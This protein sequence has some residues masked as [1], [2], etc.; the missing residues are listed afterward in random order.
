MSWWT[1]EIKRKME[2]G[3][4]IGLQKRFEH[5]EK[6]KKLFRRKKKNDKE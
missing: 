3:R 6:I 1:D 4:E 5:E 2:M